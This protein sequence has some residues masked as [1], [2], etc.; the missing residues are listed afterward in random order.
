MKNNIFSFTL[1]LSVFF[2]NPAYCQVADSLTVQTQQSFRQWYQTKA[3]NTAAVPSLLIGYGLLTVGNKGFPYSSYEAYK[4]IQQ[5]F[6]GFYTNLDDFTPLAPAAAVYGLNAVGI[7]GRHTFADRTLLLAFS[8]TVAYI[9]TIS[10][11]RSVQRLRPDGS[12]NFSFPS[13]HTAIAFVTAEFMHQEY[14]HKSVWY[15]VAGYTVASAT[16]VM[17]MLNNRHWLSDVMVGAGIG[18]VSTKVT[19]LVYPWLKEKMSRAIKQELSL[20]PVYN[21]SGISL[22]VVFMYK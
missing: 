21:G 17:R 4:D 1:I 9:S 10:L 7:K 16:G 2:I 6:P 13:G 3:F 18:M 15:S 22:V 14:K 5:H 8:G 19:Y 20:M 12:N 11:K